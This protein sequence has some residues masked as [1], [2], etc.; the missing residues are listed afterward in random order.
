[1]TDRKKQAATFNKS[2]YDQEYLKNNVYR[3][4]LYL[5]KK[6]D[7]DIIAELDKQPNRSGYIKGLIRAQMNA[8]EQ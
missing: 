5:H 3:F 1:M 7:A 4:S 2:E 8:Q 6:N